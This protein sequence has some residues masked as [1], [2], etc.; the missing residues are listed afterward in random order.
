MLLSEINPFIRFAQTVT[1]SGSREISISFDSRLFYLCNGNCKLIINDQEYFLNEDSILLWRCGIPYKFC[2]DSQLS[3]ISINFDFSQKNSHNKTPYCLYHNLQENI[4]E[5][6]FAEKI[7]FSDCEI[8]NLPIILYEMK[9]IRP[10][11]DL[12]LNEFSKKK[13][14]YEA[15][16]SALL[17]EIIVDLARSASLSMQGGVSKVDKVLDYINKNFSRD[18]T[19]ADLADLAGYHEYHLNR[20]MKSITGM[21][22]HQ[23]LTNIRI[24]KSKEYLLNADTPISEVSYLCGFKTQYHFANVFKAHTGSTP[25]NFRTAHKYNL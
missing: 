23:Y 5:K 21:S 10:K 6:S 19:N 11:I 18:I 13:F 7:H 22:I 24:E 8:L 3:I 14:G 12:I 4:K 20:I 17:K 25:S 1:V 9:K 16:C 15:I 2:T